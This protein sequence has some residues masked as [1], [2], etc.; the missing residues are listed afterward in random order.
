[1]K[2][3]GEC[4][5]RRDIFSIL[6]V[7]TILSSI[8]FCTSLLQDPSSRWRGNLL[9]ASGLG[10]SRGQKARIYFLEATSR[11]PWKEGKK[12]LVIWIDLRDDESASL[13]CTASMLLLGGLVFALRSQLC[14]L[15][16]LWRLWRPSKSPSTYH[17]ARTAEPWKDSS[18]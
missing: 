14:I 6:V 9:P 3:A 13:T 1:M 2:G 10:R 17:V 15:W 5:I 7:Q 11:F 18:H 8:C 12:A 4:R 16:R